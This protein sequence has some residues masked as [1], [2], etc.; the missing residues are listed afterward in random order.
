MAH[1]NPLHAGDMI[2]LPLLTTIS[3]QEAQ[4]CNSYDNQELLSKNLT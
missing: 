1:L 4:N 3:L 2:A